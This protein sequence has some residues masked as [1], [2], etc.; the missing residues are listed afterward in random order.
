MN[1]ESFIKK[2]L[3]IHSQNTQIIKLKKLII[4]KIETKSLILFPEIERLY[5]RIHL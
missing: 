3:R 4:E 2:Q 5:K 1:W